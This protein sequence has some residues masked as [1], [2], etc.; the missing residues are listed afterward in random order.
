MHRLLLILL[1]GLDGGGCTAVEAHAESESQ[2]AD[3]SFYPAWKDMP[4]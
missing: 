2:L 4:R 3:D 1:L